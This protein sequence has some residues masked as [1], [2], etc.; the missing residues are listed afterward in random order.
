MVSASVM[1]PCSQCT[2]AGGRSPV[3]VSAVSMKE[4]TPS[5]TSFRT[6]ICSTCAG[7]G[8]RSNE[9][10]RKGGERQCA[11]SERSREGSEGQGKVVNVQGKAVNGQGKAVPRL[12]RALRRGLNRPDVPALLR[13]PQ[14][15][16]DERRRKAVK[17]G[18]RQ[19]RS[20]FVCQRMKGR[21]NK[22]T[23]TV[24][25]QRKAVEE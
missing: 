6:S 22:A 9:R 18:D 17:G 8:G 13:S 1:Q 14:Q 5:R 7:G 21:E 11:G 16:H 20:R 4:S 24:K 15:C 12:C 19:C 10:Q 23:S 25:T 2:A 3:L